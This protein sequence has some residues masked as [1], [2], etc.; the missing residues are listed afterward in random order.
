MLSFDPQHLFLWGLLKADF[1]KNSGEASD[2]KLPPKNFCY[3][4]VKVVVSNGKGV[5]PV[6]LDPVV[7]GNTGIDKKQRA[8]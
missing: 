8:V 3:S 6:A 7:G 1:D 4:V 5:G 2:Q